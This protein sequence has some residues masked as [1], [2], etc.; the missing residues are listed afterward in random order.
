[1]LLVFLDEL[2]AVV[3]TVQE[4][5][6]RGGAVIG[7]AFKTIFARL[8]RTD[9][10]KALQDVGIGVLNAQGEVRDAIPLFNDLAAVLNNLGLRSEEAGE[11]IQKVAGVRQRD[12]LISLVE[13]LNSGQSQ[14]AKALNVSAGAA[15][16]LD[17]KN[18]ALNQTLEALINNLTI[19]SQKLSSLIGEL[20]FTDAAKD[21]VGAIAGAVNPLNDLLQGENFGGKFAQGI[22]KGIGGTLTTVGLPLIT[23][24]FLKLF[25]D[26]TKFGVDSLKQILGIN[27]AAAQQGALQQSILQTLL[28]KRKIYKEKF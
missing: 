14:F 2:L 15:G 10:L 21:I 1:M 26:L 16:S 23:A 28:I 18:Q 24:I 13:D 4:R 6:Q 25:K 7:N 20:G 27:K 3:T 5:T 17:R 11:L 8:G 12:I 9:T 19:G 22:V